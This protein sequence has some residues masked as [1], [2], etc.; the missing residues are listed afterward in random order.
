MAAHDCRGS[1]RGAHQ[2]DDPRFAAR[3]VSSLTRSGL[4]QFDRVSVR[5]EQLDLPAARARDDVASKAH[6]E[7]L[8]GA[9][10]WMGGRSRR[11]RRGSI[12]LDAAP[13]RPA[14][15][16]PRSC[17]ARSRERQRRRT[18]RLRTRTPAGASARNQVVACRT[19][20]HGSRPASDSGLRALETK[21][22]ACHLLIEINRLLLGR[23]RERGEYSRCGWKR[24]SCSSPSLPAASRPSPGLASAACSRPSSPFRWIRG[25]RSRPSPCR[26]SLAPRSGSGCGRALSIAGSS[27]ASV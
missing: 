21:P 24:S 9:R 22:R 18:T 20:P 12:R 1:G 26:T 14:T 16:G 8:H 2:G 11:E 25:S 19:P 3:H 10:R 6:P 7:L 17:R 5:I 4:E 27:G 13:G 23:Y 15:A